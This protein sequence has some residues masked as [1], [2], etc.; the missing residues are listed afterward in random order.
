[1]TTPRLARTAAVVEKAAK[2]ATFGIA[3]LGAFAVG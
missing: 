1:M 3:A 2:T